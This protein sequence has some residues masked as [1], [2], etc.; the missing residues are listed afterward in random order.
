LTTK[1]CK[2]FTILELA[3]VLVVIAIIVVLSFPLL[4]AYRTRSERIGCTSNLRSLYIAASS[5]INAAGH[6]PQISNNQTNSSEYTEQWYQVLKPYGIARI[7]WVCPS[8]QRLNGHPNLDLKDKA[9]LDYF[10]TPFDS[11]Q[12]TPY[13]WPTQPWFIER[14]N[15]HGEGNLVLFPDGSILDMK[16]VVERASMIR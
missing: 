16:R 2:A 1:N 13:K 4:A 6:W 15:M 10:A 5:Y 11:Q 14:G 9:R 8:V 12:N 3:V 7:N